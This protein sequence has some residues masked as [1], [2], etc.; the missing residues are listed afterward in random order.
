MSAFHREVSVYGS[1]SKKD[2]LQRFEWSHKE[3]PALINQADGKIGGDLR[4]RKERESRRSFM[5]IAAKKH[6]LCARVGSLAL[7]G[8]RGNAGKKRLEKKDRRAARGTAK[9]TNWGG[10]KKNCS[11]RRFRSLGMI[12]GVGELSSRN[13]AAR[14]RTCFIRTSRRLQRVT[15]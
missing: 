6:V 10:Q 1:G 14:G 7:K 15:V 8:R 11:W 9:H 12:G 4:Q 3:G 2:L 5:S 13:L